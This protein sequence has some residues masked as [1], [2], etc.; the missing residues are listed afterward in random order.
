MRCLAISLAVLGVLAGVLAS[1]DHR[2]WAAPTVRVRAYTEIV[3]MPMSRNA[4]G[5]VI[6]GQLVDRFSREPI[7]SEKLTVQMGDRTQEVYTGFNG[8]FGAEFL[9]ADGRYDLSVSYPGS[10]YLSGDLVEMSGV[11]VSKQNIEL[12]VRASAQPYSNRSIEVVLTAAT[13]EG[14]GL[15]ITVDLYAGADAES[16]K[17]LTKITTN[18][19]GRGTWKI[20]RDELGGPGRK[21]LEARFL[22]NR[23]FN[24]VTA[25]TDVEVTAPT[26][27]AFAVRESDL[28]YEDEV[29]GSGTVVDDRG[30]P[31]AG[32]PVGLFVGERRL[33]SALTNEKGA[34]V[35]EADASEIGAGKFNLQAALEPSK[36]WYGESRSSV[37][38]VQI[39]QPQPVPVTYTLAAFG[40]TAL[41]MVAFFGL[42]TKPWEK[43]L[44]RL[45]RSGNDA[46]RGNEA[47]GGNENGEPPIVQGLK[48]APTGLVS[49]LR[50]P[51]E[52]DFRGVVRDAVNQRYLPMSEVVVVDASGEEKRCIADGQGAFSFPQLSPGGARVS[53][54]AH[55]YV[56]EEFVIGLPHRGE[57]SDARVDLVPVREKI[58]A[59]YRGV[60]EG[61][62]PSVDLWG[63]W[64]PRQIFD[65]VRASRPSSALSELTNYVEETYFSQRT[66]TES[67]LNDAVLRCDRAR[68]ELASVRL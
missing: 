53:V 59:L 30:K 51:S 58:F 20:E 8:E 35:L 47:A 23:L 38:Q 4:G 40:A 43:W 25:R 2:A 44:L 41:A 13:A 63:V 21:V 3:M 28:A 60:A 18:D 15:A 5:V 55:G 45:R 9:I 17:P 1:G 33:A 24:P 61:L 66:P 46:E 27:I 34:F 54:S 12:V 42:R 36:P 14:T 49:N 65:H 10:D 32:E 6:R 67:M 64:T 68:L 37:V 26:E 62:L 11:D 7:A 52:L 56:T 19:R 29:M 31:V 48:P 39:A 57:L 22:G 50:R 16:L